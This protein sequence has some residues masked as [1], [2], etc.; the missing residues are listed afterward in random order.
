MKKIIILQLFVFLLLSCASRS[1]PQNPAEKPVFLTDDSA[2]RLAALDE[3]GLNL[4]VLQNVETSYGG[5]TVLL[6]AYYRM[7]P[8]NINLTVFSPVGS[9]L[10]DLSYD[11]KHFE[12]RGAEQ[13]LKMNPGYVIAD[14]QLC[15]FPVKAL[16]PVLAAASLKIEQIGDEEAW[17]RRIS[18][19]GDGEKSI[20]EIRRE[21]KNLYYQNF[22]RGYSYKIEEIPE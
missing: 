18:R 6:Q 20:I 13:F 14:I 2:I 22:Y 5:K 7:S 3:G 1:E 21:G 11:G 17:V 9:T 19:K 16:R 8:E 4:D 12:V 10:Y 15:Y